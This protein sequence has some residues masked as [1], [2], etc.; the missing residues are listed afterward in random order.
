[1]GPVNAAGRAVAADIAAVTAFMTLDA[2]DLP[3][4][5][6]LTGAELFARFGLPAV[7]D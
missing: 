1:M 4:V 3:A 2:F 5:D 6:T 7:P